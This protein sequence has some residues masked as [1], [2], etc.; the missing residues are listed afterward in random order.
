MPRD[1]IRPGC[2]TA[3]TRADRRGPQQFTAVAAPTQ[4]IPDMADRAFACGRGDGSLDGSWSRVAAAIVIPTAAAVESGSAD[5]CPR[6]PSA[7]ALCRAA[8][9]S[10]DVLLSGELSAPTTPACSR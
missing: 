4:T 3:D 6:T 2:V 10:A 7:C 1:D 9:R 5:N 8:G